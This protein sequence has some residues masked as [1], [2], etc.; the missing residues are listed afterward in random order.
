ME[1]R[2]FRLVP[3][4][5]IEIEHPFFNRDSIQDSRIGVGNFPGR[6][7]NRGGKEIRARLVGGVARHISDVKFRI[8]SASFLPSTPPSPPNRNIHRDTRSLNELD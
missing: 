6:G 4:F 3:F 7:G 5:Q 1:N 8:R 2:F